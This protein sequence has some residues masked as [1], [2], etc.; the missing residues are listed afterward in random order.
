MCRWRK[1]I[2]DPPLR[3]R[4]PLIPVPKFALGFLLL[5]LSSEAVYGLALPV[6]QANRSLSLSVWVLVVGLQVRRTPKV[7]ILG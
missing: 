5:L 1:A 7:L 2:F 6:L 3:A 4:L